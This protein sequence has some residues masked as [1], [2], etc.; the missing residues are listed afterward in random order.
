MAL[1]TAEKELLLDLARTT[2]RTVLDGGS[3]E[4]VTADQT[5]LTPALQEQR[6][7]FVTLHKD[8][9]LRGCIGYI[10]PMLP[11]WRAVV[12]N[13]RNAAFCDPRFAP[14]KPD[15]FGRIEIE[16]SVLTVPDKITDISEFRVGIDGI[17]LKKGFH[18]AVFLP[19]V[20]PEQ[21]WDAQTTLQYLSMKAGLPP[22]GWTSG[23]VFETFQAE[24]FGEADPEGISA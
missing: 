9:D 7:V 23:A 17:I 18:Q 13:A 16:I 21:G 22:G 20:A 10:L 11:L 2:I 5:K 8:H 4:H 15:E 1:T 14:L 3:H 6:G 12:E 19:Q 24:V